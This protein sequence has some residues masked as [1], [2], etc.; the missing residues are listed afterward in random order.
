VLPPNSQEAPHGSSAHYT[1]PLPAPLGVGELLPGSA[2]PW[3]AT[4]SPASQDRPSGM[5]TFC[6]DEHLGE[7]QSQEGWDPRSLSLRSS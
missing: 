3:L 4:R 6:L 7:G 2:W 1:A 5:E